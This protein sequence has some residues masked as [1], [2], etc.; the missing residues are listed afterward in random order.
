METSPEKELRIL[1]V[2]PAEA[3]AAEILAPLHAGGW[4]VTHALATDA[5]ALVAAL[6]HG[7]W[8]LI[9]ADYAVMGR[10]ALLLAREA[11]ATLPFIA[12]AAE[13][14]AGER[15]AF[16]RA[17]G[18]AVVSPEDSLLPIVE[19][20]LAASPEI[21]V[22][23]RAEALERFE[24]Y[25]PLVDSMI[26]EMIRTIPDQ[27]ADLAAAVAQDDAAAIELLSHSIKGAA[28]MIG[29]Q[30]VREAARVLEEIGRSQEPIA[31]T[32]ALRRL[33]EEV[34]TLLAHLRRSA[35]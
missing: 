11:G 32:A 23:D 21:V 22:F 13:M 4:S 5:P 2:G 6:G 16:S 24:G 26:A 14:D 25:E 17:G 8:D 18:Q 35:A 30:R 15:R 28:A 31:A 29:A 34:A 12:I 27:L 1:C 9:L 20:Q 7:D 10:A 3:W 33:E 19:E